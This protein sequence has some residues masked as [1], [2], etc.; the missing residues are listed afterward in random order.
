[1]AATVKLEGAFWLLPLALLLLA[2]PGSSGRRVRVVLWL[3][4]APALLWLWYVLAHDGFAARYMLTNFGP[5][6]GVAP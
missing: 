5:L 2:H 3:A 1:M 6:V 4:T